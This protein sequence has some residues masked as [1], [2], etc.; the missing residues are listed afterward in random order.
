MD[1]T[2]FEKYADA[3]ETDLGLYYCCLLYTSCCVCEQSAYSADCV[4]VGSPSRAS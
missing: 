1:D 3:A 4:S 2:L